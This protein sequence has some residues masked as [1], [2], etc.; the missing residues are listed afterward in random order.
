MSEE[1]RKTRTVDIAA[2]IIFIITG[3]FS[4]G[5]W[6]SSSQAN[7]NILFSVQAKIEDHDQ[8]ITRVED[9]VVYLKELAEEHRDSQGNGR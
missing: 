4:A 1:H 3:I 8:R 6:Y 9:A 7:A 5:A 2:M